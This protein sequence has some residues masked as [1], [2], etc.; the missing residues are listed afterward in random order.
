TALSKNPR[1]VKIPCHRVVHSDGRVGGY[2]L[3]VSEKIRLLK[4]EG[5]AVKSGK[6]A[7]FKK[8]LF[9]NFKPQ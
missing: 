2:K 6:I 1:P 8:H 3:G 5:V 7:G 4:R 9:K